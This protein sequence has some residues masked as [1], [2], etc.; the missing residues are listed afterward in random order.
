MILRNLERRP[1]R[2]AVTVA[3]IAGSAAILIAGI[4]WADALEWFI[5]VQFNR[6]QRA[7]VTIGF[8]EPVPRHARL[9]L[10]RLPG[11]KQA[12]VTRV[13]PAVLRAGHRSY[14]T[15]LTGLADDAEL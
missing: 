8:A 13:I 6:V 7:Q 4:F 1:V 9:E 15:A 11:V 14:R 12:E 2:A 3:G 10:E 5:D